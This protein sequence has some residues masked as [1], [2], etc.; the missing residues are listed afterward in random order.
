MT[1]SVKDKRDASQL[2][3][4]EQPKGSANRVVQDH[5][6]KEKNVNIWSSK[7]LTKSFFYF[8]F[9][10]FNSFYY[11]NCSVFN[12]RLEKRRLRARYVYCCVLPLIPF[13]S[14]L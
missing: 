10:K 4:E 11:Y 7:G 14:R 9:L 13:P 8:Y 2:G 12:I 5:V 3:N 1:Q 6:P